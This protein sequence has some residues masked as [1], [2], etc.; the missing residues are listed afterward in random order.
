MFVGV[1]FGAGQGPDRRISK[2]C[3]DARKS[4]WFGY[5]FGYGSRLLTRPA[6]PCLR[7]LPGPVTIAVLTPVNLLHILPGTPDLPGARC[8]KHRDIFDATPGKPAG[9][10]LT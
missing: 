2:G 10:P 8:V 9:R 6:R 4:G 3:D 1:R 7:P 5:G